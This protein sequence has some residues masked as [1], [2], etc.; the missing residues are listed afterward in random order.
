MS[1]NMNFIK[2]ILQNK[3]I[4]ISFLIIAVILFSFIG[5]KVFTAISSKL[6]ENRK[7]EARKIEKA[8]CLK[9]MPWQ[10]LNGL[11]SCD[12]IFEIGGYEDAERGRYIEGSYSLRNYDGY[13]IDANKYGKIIS[14]YPI[15]NN[16]D[17]PEKLS[18]KLIS[19]NGSGGSMTGKYYINYHDNGIHHTGSQKTWCWGENCHIE[20]VN[21]SS[22]KG[23]NA[24]NSSDSSAPYMHFN[25]YYFYENGILKDKG[26]SI[27][28]FNQSQVY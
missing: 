27:G 19:V 2:K 23:T 5:Y 17:N 14:I 12:N 3:K 6:E 9:K 21:N 8:E 24:T 26:I 20:N 15:K 18:K 25:I 16:K 1:F 7:I 28:M 13:D 4:K 10:M 22:A 11:T